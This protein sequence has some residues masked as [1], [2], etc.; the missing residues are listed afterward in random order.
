MGRRQ[1]YPFI[2]HSFIHFW[3]SGAKSW[4]NYTPQLMQH[5]HPW[6][7]WGVTLVSLIISLLSLSHTPILP[8]LLADVTILLKRGALSL[9][10]HLT[11]RHV[12]CACILFW[13]CLSHSISYLFHSCLYGRRHELVF[14]QDRPGI[15]SQWRLELPWGS[16]EDSESKSRCLS[17]TSFRG[18]PPAGT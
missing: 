9:I 3:S 10:G 18:P 12:S 6:P 15:Q 5:C 7:R 4:V 16:Q 2:I 1:R 8:S 13:C 14:T 11:A 17:C